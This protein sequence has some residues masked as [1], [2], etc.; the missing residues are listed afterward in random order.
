VYCTVAELFVAEHGRHGVVADVVADAQ[1][2]EEQL[3]GEVLFDAVV[4][5]DAVTLTSG[6]QQRH[7]AARSVRQRR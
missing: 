6:Q 2:S 1:S 5:E 7:V 4:D 3:D